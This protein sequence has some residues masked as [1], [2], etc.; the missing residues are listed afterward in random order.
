MAGDV[1]AGTVD[2]VI[3]ESFDSKTFKISF[4]GV[5]RC[6]LK[7]IKD[8][9][10]QQPLPPKDFHRDVKTIIDISVDA[11]TFQ[12]VLPQAITHSLSSCISHLGFQNQQT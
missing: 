2:V 5:E 3:N 8:L 7:T 6:H 1:V 10:S 11:A 12:D 9:K 4:V